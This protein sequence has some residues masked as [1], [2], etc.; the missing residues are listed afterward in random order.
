MWKYEDF[1]IQ[2]YIWS[3]SMAERNQRIIAERADLSSSTPTA[4]YINSIYLELKNIHSV[5]TTVRKERSFG[6]WIF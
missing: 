1:G 5:L 3:K 4:A 2:Q 6:C